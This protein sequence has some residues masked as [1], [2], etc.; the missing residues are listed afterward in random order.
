[1]MKV[2]AA[3]TEWDSKA[4]IAV[5]L[6]SLCVDTIVVGN[7]AESPRRFY[8]LQLNEPKSPVA[9]VWSSGLGSQLSLVY[10]GDVGIVGHDAGLTWVNFAKGSQM[11]TARLGGVFYEFGVVEQVDHVFVFHELGVLRAD[12]QGSVIWSVDTDIL[13]QWEI[14]PSGELLLT[15]LDQLGKIRVDG[16]LGRYLPA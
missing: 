8:T 7:D 6:D 10:H 12:L 4:T 13:E 2:I 15:I 11:A 16:A 1:M 14:N 5:H 9:A 3:T